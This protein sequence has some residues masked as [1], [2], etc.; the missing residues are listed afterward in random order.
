[1][2]RREAAP[3]DTV[4]VGDAQARVAELPFERA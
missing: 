3:G 4:A 1:L 2:V